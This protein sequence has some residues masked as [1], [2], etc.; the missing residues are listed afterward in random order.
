M[1]RI[2]G[3][4]PTSAMAIETEYGTS[5]GKGQRCFST[6]ANGLLCVHVKGQRSLLCHMGTF[7]NITKSEIAILLLLHRLLISY[8]GKLSLHFD[9]PSLYSC[10]VWSLLLKEIIRIPVHGVS[11]YS[12]ILYVR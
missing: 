8:K 1:L 11:R 10:C 9:P 4:V 5:G 7:I 6:G 12:W 3:L 2:I